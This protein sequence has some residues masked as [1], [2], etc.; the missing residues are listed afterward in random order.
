M[1]TFTPLRLA[2]VDAYVKSMTDNQIDK[3]NPN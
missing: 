1:K 2:C 3:L